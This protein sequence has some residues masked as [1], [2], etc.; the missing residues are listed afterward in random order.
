MF[1]HH[2]RR[3]SL[4]AQSIDAP[5]QTFALEPLEERKLMSVPGPTGWVPYAQLIRQAQAAAAFPY[6]DGSSL[7]VAVVDRGIDYNHPQITAAKIV[8]GYNFR[9]NTYNI[10]DDYGHGTG[11]TGIIAANP[12]DY[13]GY[14]QGV[15]PGTHILDLK[16]ESSATVKQALDFII[17][18]HAY[19]NIQVVN[20]TDFV[21]NLPDPSV[22]D[23]TVYTTELKALHDLNIFVVT[24]AGNGE[25]K[26]FQLNGSAEP[27]SLPGSSPYVFAAGGSTLSDTIWEDSVRGTGLG[28]LGP[29]DRVTMTYYVF[30]RNADGTAAN[31]GYSVWDD[32]FAGSPVNVDYAIGTS[33]ASAYAA[34]TGALLKQL[35][36]AFTPDQIA[37]IITST[38][39]QVPDNE[40]AGVTWPRLNIYN[41]LVKGF[42]M[43]DDV[44]LG[45]QDFS[46]A[47]SLQFRG[48][49]SV[50]TNLKLTIGHP[51]FYKFTVTR[52]STVGISISD[53]TAS[54]FS[55]LFDS[56]HNVVRQ[57]NV[58]KKS[59]SNNTRLAAGTYY[60]YLTSPTTLQGAYGLTVSGGSSVAPAA[61]RAAVAG[62]STII[63]PAAAM[64]STQSS[65]S[66]G[67]L[68]AVKDK[69][70]LA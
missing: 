4:P 10:L 64:A 37:Q 13:G 45:N 14:N 9:D 21:S 35:N 69:S 32:Q 1:H 15:A 7:N 16:Q 50:Q 39:D 46:T 59:S 24:P 47:T 36:P 33:W 11:V 62:G 26:Y 27:L 65:A 58:G 25:K 52:S 5:N 51:D 70:L 20:L 44:N 67:I 68:G 30:N 38:G 18:N 29:S 53:A 31:P 61:A 17:A 2:T 12:Y 48:G 28:I 66:N 63:T 55:L 54:P 19:Y 22:F 40:R 34:G 60:I 6:L 8:G 41:A 49:K 42:Q 56:N 57:L 43:S 3:T 23:P